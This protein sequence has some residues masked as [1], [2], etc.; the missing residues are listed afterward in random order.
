MSAMLHVY[1]VDHR[2]GPNSWEFQGQGEA[3]PRPH[4]SRPARQQDGGHCRPKQPATG[5]RGAAATQGTA[6]RRCCPA[7]RPTRGARAERGRRRAGQG[8]PTRSGAATCGSGGRSAP[9][10][11]AS[12]F[13]W[14]RALPTAIVRTC[15]R[16][17]LR[18]QASAVTDTAKPGAPMCTELCSKGHLSRAL[19]R[20]LA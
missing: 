20:C 12:M 13:D 5:V 19:G 2:M 14:N 18:A 8:A 10:G 16:V 7:R 9:S 6:K 3:G 4:P 1:D 17:M 15:K 11:K